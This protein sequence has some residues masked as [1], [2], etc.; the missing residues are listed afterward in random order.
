MVV[1]SCVC[2]W[3]TVLVGV[4]DWAV[5]VGQWLWVCCGVSGVGCGM[6]WVCGGCGVVGV[7]W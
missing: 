3:W 5:S 6:W 1:V 2:G 4:D 7:L